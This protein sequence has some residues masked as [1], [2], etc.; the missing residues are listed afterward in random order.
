MIV[1][2]LGHAPCAACD[3]V[4]LL[5][6]RFNPEVL[7]G[8]DPQ[9]I[10]WHGPMDDTLVILS[11]KAAWTHDGLIY[12]REDGVA[13][14]VVG[15][16]MEP[17]LPENMWLTPGVIPRLV[18]CFDLSAW[19]LALPEEEVVVKL[20]AE[21]S[22]YTLL[23]HLIETGAIDRISLLLMEWHGDARIEVPCPQKDWGH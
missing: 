17:V 21:A 20:D 16:Q 15:T 12:F 4:P 1:V 22:E 5:V 2:D 18:E 9:V 7:Y 10:T 19:L 11:P 14:C 6:E 13:S 3:S 8:F 23:P